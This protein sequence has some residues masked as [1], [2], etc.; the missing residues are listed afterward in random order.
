MIEK[1][2]KL[3]II[4]HNK[5]KEKKS[6]KVSNKR[7]FFRSFYMLWRQ[8]FLFEVSI[9]YGDGSMTLLLH[10][11]FMGGVMPLLPDGGMVAA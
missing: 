11:V 7:H 9:H 4:K 5:R 6:V 3:S 1:W 10:L 2:K 8:V